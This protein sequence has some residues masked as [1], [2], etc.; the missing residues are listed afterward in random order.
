M[1]HVPVVTSQEAKQQTASSYHKSVLHSTAATAASSSL[2]RRYPGAV[3]LARQ[4]AGPSRGVVHPGASIN[5]A[6]RERERE[7][8]GGR[9]FSLREKAGESPNSRH[10]TEKKANAARFFHDLSRNVSGTRTL[11]T[12]CKRAIKSAS[13]LFLV[14]QESRLVSFSR[15]SRGDVDAFP[16]KISTCATVC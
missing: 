6:D 7:K 10:L 3:F 1:S 8:N 9:S 4:S 2:S 5:K 14:L 16:R 13:S 11:L 12:R 15:L